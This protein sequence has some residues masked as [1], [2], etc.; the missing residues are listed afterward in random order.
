MTC[1]DLRSRFVKRQLREGYNPDV[2]RIQ[3]AFPVS[4]LVGQD[5]AGTAPFLAWFHAL[6]WN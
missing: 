3:V 2:Y 5:N 1:S 6:T 4:I